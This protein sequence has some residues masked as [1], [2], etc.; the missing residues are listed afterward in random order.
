MATLPI[1]NTSQIP[2]NCK[3]AESRWTELRQ[4]LSRLRKAQSMAQRKAASN[5]TG[6]ARSIADTS[7]QTQP[8]HCDRFWKS[9]SW[10]PEAAAQSRPPQTRTQPFS[11][12][13]GVGHKTLLWFPLAHSSSSALA[14]GCAA[15]LPPP[16]DPVTNLTAFYR[17]K[18]PKGQWNHSGKTQTGNGKSS[19]CPGWLRWEC[20]KSLLEQELLKFVNLQLSAEL[21]QTSNPPS[22]KTKSPWTPGLQNL[23]INTFILSQFNWEKVN[24]SNSTTCVIS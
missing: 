12:G 17:L 7:L 1:T 2:W 13:S 18:K 14:G 22:A 4:A 3:A 8:I 15:N 24:T 5:Q 19:S 10:C 23:P 9:S 11:K 16:P 6:G 20:V 21:P